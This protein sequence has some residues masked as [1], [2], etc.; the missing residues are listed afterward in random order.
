MMVY[1]YE[2]LTQAFQSNCPPEKEPRQC[3]EWQGTLVGGYGQLRFSGKRYSAHRVSYELFH[4]P[5]PVGM[6]VCHTCDNRKCV[7]PAHLWLG[8][9]RD[10]MDDK[11]AKGR[12]SRVQG[13]QQQSVKL[14]V[15]Q[16]M[17]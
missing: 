7:N 15:Y 12:Q 13:R 4:G 10:N 2:S 8:T 17:E 11:V 6:H 9:N 14:T 1:R 5:I 3:W 16:V